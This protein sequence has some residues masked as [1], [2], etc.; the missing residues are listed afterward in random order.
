MLVGGFVWKMWGKYYIGMSAIV[1]PGV[2]L[3]PGESVLDKKVAY[4]VLSVLEVKRGDCIIEEKRVGET[5][6]P[7]PLQSLKVVML[8]KSVPVQFTYTQIIG[9]FHL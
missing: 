2:L 7:H 4:N 9:I 6:L 3:F 1:G 5:Q 8:R